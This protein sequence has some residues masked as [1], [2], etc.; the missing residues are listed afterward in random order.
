MMIGLPFLVALPVP[1]VARVEC[2]YPSLAFAANEI[3]LARV[4]AKKAHFRDEGEVPLRA[5]VLKGDELLTD[6]R[7]GDFV[8][9]TYI[10]KTGVATSGWLRLADV[11]VRVP[12]AAQVKAWLG[13]WTSGKYQNLT[14]KRGS[15]P[16]WLAV[17]GAAYWAMSDEAAETGGLHEG[18]VDGEAPV[19]SGVLGFTQSDDGTYQPYSETARDDY[20]CAIRLRLIGNS[21]LAAED[22]RS[23]GGANV[24]FWG[25]YARGK[26][27]FDNP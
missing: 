26:V 22:S 27:E 3:Q 2:G 8:C 20:K 10:G 19:E 5:F 24:S 25:S 21:Y 23:C 17:S 4:K 7:D 11:E 13:D 18:S 15:K 9:A 14:I 12:E 16:E 6:T 1:A